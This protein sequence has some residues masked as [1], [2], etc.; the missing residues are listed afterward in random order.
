MRMDKLIERRF[1]ELTEEMEAVGAGAEWIPDAETLIVPRDAFKG[2][3]TSA[4]SLLQR[5]FGEDSIHYQNLLAEFKAFRGYSSELED[6]RA[7]FLAAKE[8]YEGG[9]LFNVRALVK[10]EVLVD[11]VLEQATALLQAEYKDPACVLA[12]VALETTLKEL[13][14]SKGISHN[15]ADRMN[16]DLC[17]AEVYNM[18]MQKQITAW[19]HLRNAAAHG[20]WED[21]NNAQ[22]EDMVNGVS[23]FIADYL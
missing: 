7:I 8:D 23:R 16:A 2:W 20:N 15:K 14:T 10:A 22:V 17:K 3:A 21:Y 4:L 11:D 1:S 18:G 13:A 12:G 19:L 5:T 9:Y 6:C